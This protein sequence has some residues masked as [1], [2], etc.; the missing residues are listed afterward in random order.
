[1]MATMTR[2][3]GLNDLSTRALAFKMIG[4]GWYIA[5][6]LGAGLGGGLLLDNHYNTLPLFTFLLLT[7][8]LFIAFYGIYRM[9][10]PLIKEAKNQ[11][12]AIGKEGED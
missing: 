6:C 1:M 4:I 7:L 2:Q 3:N 9:V 5:F 10:R 11:D 8:G 12:K